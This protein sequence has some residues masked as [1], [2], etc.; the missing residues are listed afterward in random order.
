MNV[1]IGTE[2]AQ[3]FLGMFVSNFLYCVVAV[4]GDLVLYMCNLRAGVAE[5]GSLL[6]PVQPHKAAER[7]QALGG[8][9]HGGV[10]QTGRQGQ[11]YF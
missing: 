5:H 6:R 11:P 10:L 2:A 3:F 4:Y 9:D 8:Q 7:L 1:E